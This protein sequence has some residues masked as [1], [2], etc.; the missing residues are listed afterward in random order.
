MIGSERPAS[1]SAKPTHEFRI[2]D[3]PTRNRK[4]IWDG[5]WQF[6]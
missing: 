3:I 5:C 6:S 4:N 2:V 1:I